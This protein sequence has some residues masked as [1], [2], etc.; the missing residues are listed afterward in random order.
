M[1]KKIRSILV[2]TLLISTALPIVSSLDKNIENN[3][4]NDINSDEGFLNEDC[5]CGNPNGIRHAFGI[6]KE[7]SL[8]I[9]PD[10]TSMKPVVMD[11]PG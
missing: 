8:N 3:Y 5:E 6:M 2:M 9:H 10:E 1:N 11:I 7:R 4:V